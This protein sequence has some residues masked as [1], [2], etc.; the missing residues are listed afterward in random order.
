[1]VEQAWVGLRK[2][3]AISVWSVLGQKKSLSNF[4]V[5]GNPPILVG[6]APVRPAI[7]A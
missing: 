2:V 6:R 7:T 5:L 4:G 1:M 3:W